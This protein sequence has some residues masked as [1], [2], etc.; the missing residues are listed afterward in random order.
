MSSHP[1]KVDR[2]VYLQRVQ[3]A[4]KKKKALLSDTT[5]GCNTHYQFYKRF[6]TF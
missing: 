5:L 2:Q 3:C 4:M 1:A 6:L